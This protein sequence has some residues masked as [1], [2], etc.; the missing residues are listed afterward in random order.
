MRGAGQNFGIVVSATLT[1]FPQ[2]N[3]GLHYDGEL[4]FTGDKLE[5][6]FE[7]TNKLMDEGWP[8]ELG[9]GLAFPATQ[10]NKVRKAPIPFFP[11][12]RS[13]CPPFQSIIA[14]SAIFA[15]PASS[16]HKYI[17]QYAALGPISFTEDMFT[18]AE[19]G[20]KAA[21]GLI[22]AGCN[23]DRLRSAHT[24]NQARFDVPT[25]RAGFDAWANFTKIHTNLAPWS[26]QLWEVFGT[27]GVKAHPADSTAYP[28]R[29]HVEI[30]QLV[31]LDYDDP[32]ISD[33]AN[34]YAK[35]WVDRYRQTSG[36]DKWYVYQNY[37][38]DDEPLEAMYGYEPWRLARLRRL[39]KR[40]DPKDV[41]KGYH[42]FV[43][44]GKY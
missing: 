6:V 8:A 32:T 35:E 34:T 43:V 11:P 30:L 12:T 28:N 40:Y 26:G 1:T 33:V 24:L 38:F 42:D 19:L 21:G 23:K 13:H 18:W 5:A 3:D 4:F 29:D 25:M 31:S 36:Y 7:L 17:S 37:A 16:A 20:H 2:T 44:E 39:K 27:Q 15:G 10:N 22:A 9:A 14:L 41:F